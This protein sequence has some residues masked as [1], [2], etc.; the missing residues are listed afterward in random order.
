MA[1]KIR[2]QRHGKKGKPV[3]HIVVADSRS[4]R[5]GKNIEKLGIYV[6]TTNPATIELNLDKAVDWLEK[7]AQPSDTAKS[8]LSFKGA[9]LKKHLNGGVKKG[10]FSAEDAEKKFQDWLEHKE[11][12]ILT[13]KEKLVSSKE[14][15]K[16]EKLEAEKK[17]NE[18]RIAAQQKALEEEN[19][20]IANDA[21]APVT[22][23]NTSADTEENKNE[24]TN[25]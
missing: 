23:E 4:K 3:Y 2:L 13:K 21:E 14:Q 15:A 1:V 17:I 16:K 20:E 19:Q 10:A 24:E 5:D 6:P 18:A 11:K 25:A 12:S 22:E 7:G 8:I 9:L